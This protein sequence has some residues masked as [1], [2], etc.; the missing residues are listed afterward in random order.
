MISYSKVC[1]ILTDAVPMSVDLCPQYAIITQDKNVNVCCELKKKVED[2]FDRW[3]NHHG[4][5]QMSVNLV[6]RGYCKI[7]NFSGNELL[8]IL[9]HII[10]KTNADS[11]YVFK[12]GN[13]IYFLKSE[14][15]CAAIMFTKTKPIVTTPPADGSESNENIKFKHLHTKL[16]NDR[17]VEDYRKKLHKYQEYYSKEYVEELRR[18]AKDRYPDF[19]KTKI[20]DSSDL[21]PF[22]DEFFAMLVA[23]A[24]RI[25][26]RGSPRTMPI[27]PLKLDI[28][29]AACIKFAFDNS[30]TGKVTALCGE[31]GTR[32]GRDSLWK[33]RA[34]SI[35]DS[36]EKLIEW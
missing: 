33:A 6:S 13:V 26:S 16:F 12:P 3:K 32:R 15:A 29:F 20:K 21:F 24:Y 9:C 25:G 4:H 28:P 35:K 8:R 23:I 7:D 30:Q 1:E 14:S 34:K 31:V 18:E 5:H 11:A 19:L 10:N 36:A 17:L 22:G 27:A 2:N